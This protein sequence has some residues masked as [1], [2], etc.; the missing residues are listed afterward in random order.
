MR[1]VLS[2]LVTVSLVLSLFIGVF[3]PVP[4]ARAFTDGPWTYTLA[5]GKATITGYTG[6]GGAIVI[7][8]TLG[9][10]PVSS[11]GNYAFMNCTGLTSVTI[12]NS[13][14]SLGTHAFFGCTGLT[15]VTIGSGVASIGDGTF[16]GCTGLTTMTIPNNVTAIGG[17]AF[18]ACT[19]LTTVT[20][21][22]SL[23]TIGDRAFIG[24]AA[25]IG[26]T[27][28]NGVTSIGYGTFQ[29]CAGL[30]TVTIP[31]SVTS[32]GN[33][34]FIGCTGL[35]SV[36]IGSSVTTIDIW[37]F[38]YCAKL[39]SVTI[40]D[41]VTSIGS[42]AFMLCSGLTAAHF[43]GNAPTMGTSVF[44]SCATGFKVWYIC[45]KTGWTNPWH[46]Y[47][48]ANNCSTVT[49]LV[50]SA[51]WNLVSVAYPLP[52]ASIS[53]LQAVYGYHNTW[54]VPTTLTPGQAYW[55][56]VQNAV[57][58]PLPGTPSTAP[59][60]LTCQAG[61]QL[62]GNPFD[63]PLPITSITNHGYI[64]TCYSYGPTW[65]VLNPSTD[66]LQPG[67]GYWIYLT[68]PTTLTLTHP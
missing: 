33:S 35:T 39:T 26:V 45:G 17:G 1:K 21:P 12:P 19:A 47:P 13:V 40:P 41:S 63:V 7:P 31:N 29:D 59:V 10:S 37:A 46:G 57:T 52:V 60:S 22:N 5:G 43:L 2:V 48:T 42:D 20:I 11:L 68:A 38:S 44:A 8:S 58:V 4:S 6:P 65:G 55:V 23:T 32:I 51:S 53:G 49:S 9:G 54:S 64:T 18:E 15:G 28:P 14:T 30:T 36:S 50:L 62:L 25:L 16:Y 66:S 34:A 67:R 27:I 56:Q 61:W 3:A 24:C